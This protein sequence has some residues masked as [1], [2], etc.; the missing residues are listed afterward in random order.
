MATEHAFA[1]GG[2]ISDDAA[3]A[4]KAGTQWHR[5]ILLAAGFHHKV[6]FVAC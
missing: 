6:F 4:S 1:G 5:E 3:T 2:N